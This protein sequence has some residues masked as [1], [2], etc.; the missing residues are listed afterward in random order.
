MRVGIFAKFFL[1]K[2]TEFATNFCFSAKGKNYITSMGISITVFNLLQVHLSMEEGVYEQV[3]LT[4]M[5]RIH[6]YQ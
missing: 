5:S 2:N 6:N 1:Q 3:D 4:G